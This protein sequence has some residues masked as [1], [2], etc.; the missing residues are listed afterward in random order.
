MVQFWLKVN[1]LIIKAT[2]AI[3][4]MKFNVIIVSKL[5]KIEFH[6]HLNSLKQ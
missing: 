1:P 3:V 5:P 4:A 2:F 6:K